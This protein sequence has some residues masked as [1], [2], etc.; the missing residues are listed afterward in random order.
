MIRH[1]INITVS[2]AY[3]FYDYFGKKTFSAGNL[4]LADPEITDKKYQLRVW[5][6]FKGLCRQVSSLKQDQKEDPLSRATETTLP[7]AVL[8]VIL[9]Q[10][11][12]GR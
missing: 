6:A 9:H 4:P 10:K 12:H 1:N 7:D 5:E 2:S 11:H 3:L 8:Q